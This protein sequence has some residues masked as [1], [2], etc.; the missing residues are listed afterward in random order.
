MEKHKAKVQRTAEV[1]KNHAVLLHRNAQIRK[2][3]HDSAA[4]ARFVAGHF[5]IPSGARVLE[6]G[7]GNGRF[8]IVLARRTGKLVSCDLDRAAMRRARLNLRWHRLEKKVR[9]V[10]ADATRLPFRDGLFDLVVSVNTLHH[11]SAPMRALREMVRVLR[12]GGTL[13][14]ADFNERGFRAMDRL[15][16]SEGN[17][18]EHSRFSMKGIQSFLLR[19]R[20]Q[21]HRYIGC[22]QDMVV[23]SRP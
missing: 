18:H 8:T 16:R 4:S 14:V 7:T 1:G 15:H 3:G 23:A 12:R 22:N 5:H 9:L 6:V 21:V 19:S 20:M 2:F 10:R 11:V 17:R 13:I